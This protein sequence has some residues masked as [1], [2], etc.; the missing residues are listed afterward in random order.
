MDI[1]KINIDNVLSHTKNQMVYASVGGAHLYGWNDDSSDVD[2][3]GCFITPLE[4]IIGLHKPRDVIE[5]RDTPGNFDVVLFELEKELKLIIS[6]NIN[7]YENLF[8]P[9]IIFQTP[10]YHEMV[11]IANNCMSQR[12]TDS[13]LGLATHNYRKYILPFIQKESSSIPAKK[14]LYVLRA[15]MCGI[16]VLN[17]GVVESNIHILNRKFDIRD[18]DHLIEVKKSKYGTNGLNYKRIDKTIQELMVEIKA[19]EQDSKLPCDNQ[20]QLSCVNSFL[21]RARTGDVKK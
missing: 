21:I 18:I 10:M 7:V 11:T 9:H 17:T 12:I 2:I 5:R 8:S 1:E 20:N 6:N 19:A 15:L 14:F 16:Y 4:N 3:H 13:C